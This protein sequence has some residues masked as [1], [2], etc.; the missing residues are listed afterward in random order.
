LA[1]RVPFWEE[2][3]LKSPH[4]RG[5][6]NENKQKALEHTELGRVYGE[7]KIAL[8]ERG[9]VGDWLMW[10]AEGSAGVT[11]KGSRKLSKG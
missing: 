4:P 8:R 3:A 11:A 10:R 9:E 5:V 6:C 1:G 2:F 7:W